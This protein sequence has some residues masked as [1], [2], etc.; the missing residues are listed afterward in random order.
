MTESITTWNN[1]LKIMFLPGNVTESM[2]DNFLLYQF[3][4]D[5]MNVIPFGGRQVNFPVK[6]QRQSGFGYVAAGSSSLPTATDS[7]ALE[8]TVNVRWTYGIGELDDMV[9]AVSKSDATAYQNARTQV[10]DDVLMS[11]KM[12][13]NAGWYDDGRS[14]M[15][16]LPAAD[17]QTTITVLQPNHAMQGMR[18]DLMDD[19]DWSTKLLSGAPIT[20]VDHQGVSTNLLQSTLT[21]SASAPSGTA[22]D[23]AFVPE[24]SI[25]G[26]GV[27]RGPHGL[28]SGCIAGNPQ[29]ENYL[30]INRSTAA[31][32]AWKGSEVGNAGTNIQWSPRRAN[33]VLQLIRRRSAVSIDIASIVGINNW[34]IAQEIYETIAPDKQITVPNGDAIQLVPGFATASRRSFSVF[35]TMNGVNKMYADEMAPANEQFWITPSTWHIL[36]TNPPELADEDGNIFHRFEGRPALQFRWRFPHELY[37]TACSA[38]GILLD[39]AETNP[40]S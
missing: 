1:L 25:S 30:N 34:N 7:V 40:V 8:A 31:N 24:N 39:I 18:L 12:F 36:Q 22:A 29:L 9:I 14:R 38:N 4:L 23:D 16:V 13:L 32:A 3:A 27:Q 5:N 21:T 10:I 17:N 20:A 15:A 19:S 6:T 11:M 37:T 35:A 33:A 26:A 28:R 2:R